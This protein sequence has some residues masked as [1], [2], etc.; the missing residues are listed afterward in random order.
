[1]LGIADKL[2]REKYRVDTRDVLLGA[3]SVNVTTAGT[4]FSAPFPSFTLQSV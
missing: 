2:Q 1:M 4:D 3:S